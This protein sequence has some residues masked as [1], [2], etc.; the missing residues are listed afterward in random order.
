MENP[1]ESKRAWKLIMSSLFARAMPYLVTGFGEDK[2]LF[3]NILP[4]QMRDNTLDAD[5]C[6]QYVKF[7]IRDDQKLIIDAFPLLG[8]A[9]IIL[10]LRSVSGDIN[11]FGIEKC[12]LVLE[13]QMVYCKIA[14]RDDNAQLA[15]LKTCGRLLSQYEMNYYLGYYDRYVTR[16]T[17]N[18]FT[19]VISK[20]DD[21]DLSA[22]KASINTVRVRSSV[23]GDNGVYSW[24]RLPLVDGVNFPSLYEY[25]KKSGITGYILNAELIWRN[26]S[27]EALVCYDDKFLSVRSINPRRL[28]YP[29]KE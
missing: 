18:Q 23:P 28:W 15:S 6:L 8:S 22:P 3:T 26:K 4:E 13:N 12:S 7:N 9:A 16:K 10:N 1:K 17:L 27:V 19:A 25:I 11:K 24:F 20:I 5:S 14:G 21:K 29:V 2:W